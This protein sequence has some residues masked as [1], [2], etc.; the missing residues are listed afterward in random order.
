M[1]T[2]N[3]KKKM[4]KKEFEY[5]IANQ[6]KFVSEYKGKFL[7]IKEQLIIGIYDTEIEAYNESIKEHALGT[8]LIQECQPGEENYT[9][10]FRTRVIFR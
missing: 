8:F 5:Y 9:Q 7:V 1:V 4:L 6:D 3:T 2:K 10:T